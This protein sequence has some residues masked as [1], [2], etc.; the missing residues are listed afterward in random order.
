M[1]YGKW[2]SSL[3]HTVVPEVSANSASGVLPYGMMT[4]RVSLQRAIDKG[5]WTK[6]QLREVSC[7]L[8]CA[9]KPSAF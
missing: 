8:S 2:C 4:E 5:K 1:E 6:S 3:A 7:R 9:F